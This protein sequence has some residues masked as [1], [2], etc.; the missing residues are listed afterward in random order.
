MKLYYSPG[1]CSLASHIALREAGLQFDLE[2]V[3]TRTKKLAD[4][5]DYYAVTPKGY[6]PALRLDDG[7]IL[8]E[9]TAIMPFIADQKPA[10]KLAPAAG[11]RARHRL[12]EW[13]GYINSEVHKTL[14]GLFN[15][16]AT[17]DMKKMAREN[18]AKRF[19]FL[20]KHLSTR[21]YVMDDYTVADAYLFTI[22]N[23]TKFVGIDLAKWPALTAFQA[24]IA[25]RPA[26]QAALQAEGLLKK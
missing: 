16:A 7:E 4:G 12:H 2:K 8:T 6:V 11:T 26:V 10:A 15:P 17:E 13:L 25:S 20:E 22:L 9:G 5:G 21:E 14:G 3:D 23:W 24:R 18:S 19:D 1:A